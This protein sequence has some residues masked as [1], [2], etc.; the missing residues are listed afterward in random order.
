[1]QRM[2]DVLGC[3]AEDYRM[4]L[5]CTHLLACPHCQRERLFLGLKKLAGSV[6]GG[7]LGGWLC[8]DAQC[9]TDMKAVIL[10]HVRTCRSRPTAQGGE[11]L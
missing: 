6:V 11:T 8:F 7:D 5:R 9:E 4:L 1:M 10:Q 2:W 3:P